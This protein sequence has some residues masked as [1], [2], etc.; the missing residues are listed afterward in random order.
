MKEKSKADASPA[1]TH[2]DDDHNGNNNNQATE[3]IF[4]ES[5]ASLE[6][7]SKIDKVRI[8]LFVSAR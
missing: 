2:A 8:V 7:K 3:D 4:H 6:L 1:S 5:L